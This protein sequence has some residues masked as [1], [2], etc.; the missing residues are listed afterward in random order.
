MGFQSDSEHGVDDKGRIN[1]P[2]RFRHSVGQKF[3]LTK[4]IH[5]CI[6]LFPEEEYKKLSERLSRSKPFSLKTL[7]LQRWFTST[8]AGLDGQNRL[9]IP[10]RLREYA[11]IELQGEAVLVGAETR[12]EIWSKARW[13]AYTAAL[14]DETILDAW[15]S[16]YADEDAGKSA[17]S[18]AEE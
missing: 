8:E 3:Y 18:G 11:G 5:G 9:S 14:S 1:M 17:A 10:M 7:Q 2:V 4:G 15:D 13:E 6:F 16:L 12:I